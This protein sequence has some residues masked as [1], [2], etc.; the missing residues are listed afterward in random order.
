MSSLIGVSNLMNLM[1]SEDKR[2]MNLLAVPVQCI[3]HY[4]MQ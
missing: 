3:G 2:R 4:E 1:T